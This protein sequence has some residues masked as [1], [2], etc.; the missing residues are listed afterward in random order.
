MQEAGA[1]VERAARCALLRDRNAHGRHGGRRPDREVSL[2]VSS[3]AAD[4][5]FTAKLIDVYP[6][7]RDYPRGNGFDNPQPVAKGEIFRVTI[8]PF[9]T[10]N[11]FQKGRRLRLDISSSI[12]PKFDVNPNVFAPGGTGRRVARNTVFLGTPRSKHRMENNCPPC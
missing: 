4:T 6:P 9:A 12:F 11:L 3:D 10:A 1:A 7:S 2:W 5:D 8:T